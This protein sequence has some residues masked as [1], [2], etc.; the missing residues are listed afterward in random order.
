MLEKV[1]V[2]ERGSQG[3][4]PLGMLKLVRVLIQLALK[5]RLFEV[6]GQRTVSWCSSRPNSPLGTNPKRAAS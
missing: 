6:R 1:Q 4:P 2:A 5:G 3:L